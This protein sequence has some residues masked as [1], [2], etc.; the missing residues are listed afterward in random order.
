MKSIQKTS[1]IAASPIVGLLIKSALLCSLVLLL[2]NLFVTSAESHAWISSL[3]LA[4]AGAGYALLQIQ[5]RPD[6]STMMK[7]LL[8]A[9]TFVLWAIDQ[10]LPSGR[11]AVF[12]GDVV[13]AAYVLD[14]FWIIGEQA[15]QRN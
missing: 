12:L 5:L 10:L 14:L 13:I 6:R 11:L 9:A 1:P 7:R 2:S 8:L 4:V 3:P 15:A